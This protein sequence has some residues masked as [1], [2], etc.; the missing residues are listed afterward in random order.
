MGSLHILFTSHSQ[1]LFAARLLFSRW[2]TC[3]IAVVILPLSMR[4][5]VGDTG[6]FCSM[7]SLYRVHDAF[8]IHIRPASKPATIMAKSDQQLARLTEL[9]VPSTE[10]HCI[11]SRSGWHRIIRIDQGAG[12]ISS[13][14]YAE[15]SSECLLHY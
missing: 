1:I 7:F 15:R 13:T 10:M 6:S 5:Q 14:G 2:W 4:V 12:R 8:G 3:I 11:T 9:P